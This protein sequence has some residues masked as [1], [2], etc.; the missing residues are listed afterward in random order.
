MTVV[1]RVAPIP[2]LTELTTL[3]TGMPIIN[4][5]KIETSKSAKTGFSFL[6]IK[7]TRRTIAKRRISNCIVYR[8]KR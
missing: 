7:T 4:P 5:V 3:G 8:E 2:E 1:P 6:M